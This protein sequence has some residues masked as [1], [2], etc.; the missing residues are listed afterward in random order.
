[1]LG[2]VAVVGTVRS[3]HRYPVKS[4]VGEALDE[5]DVAV[6]GIAG[7]RTW[8]VRNLDVGEQQGARKLPRLLG[9][10]AW[11]SPEDGSTPIVGF[12][13]GSTLRADSEDASAK[14]GAH[15]GA[16]VELVSLRMPAD[17]SH[18]RNARLALDFPRLREELG[19]LSG[20]DAPDISSLG[21]RK[22]V[23]LFT[24]ATPRGTYFDVYPL[25]V[26]T[27]SSLRYVAERSGNPNID[28]RRYRPNFVIDSGD[29]EGLLEPDWE[30]ASVEIG[31][32]KIR[33]EARTIRCS[34]PGR[35]QAID[36]IEADKAVVRAVAEHA[37][38]HLGAYAVVER[39]GRVRVGDPVRLLEPRERPLEHRVRQAEQAVARAAV[40]FL[41]RDRSPR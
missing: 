4:M 27:T 11:F 20:E 14:V 1:M 18:F 3:L 17:A 2:A 23:E 19:V 5:L 30:G 12:P 32:C 10:R 25:H 9:L 31:E 7:D 26:L 38:R 13:D 29:T 36:G 8:A 35:A 15:V 21:L 16:R 40:R 37:D 39:P 6:S 34:I 28:A 33:I 24:Y 22:L 41:L